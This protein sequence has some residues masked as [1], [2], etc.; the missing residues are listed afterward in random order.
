MDLPDIS[1]GEDAGFPALYVANIS[2][3]VPD[4][5]RHSPGYHVDAVSLT[6]SHRLYVLHEKEEEEDVGEPLAGH[7]PLG[8]PAAS[9][10]VPGVV[11]AQQFIVHDEL[12]EGN[13]FYFPEGEILSPIREFVPYL[14]DVDMQPNKSRSSVRSRLGEREW[15]ADRWLQVIPLSAVSMA[16]EEEGRWRAR[17]KER[18]IWR[19]I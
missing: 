9:I 19:R 7:S 12:E 14:W 3:P 1:E 13:S 16:V 4:V 8:D 6:L 17:R 18:R 5:R 10:V 15:A 2:N 11:A